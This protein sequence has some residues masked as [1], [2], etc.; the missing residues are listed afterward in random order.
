MNKKYFV[1]KIVFCIFLFGIN[2]SSIPVIAQE[3]LTGHWIAR[4]VFDRNRGGNSFSTATMVLVNK[5]GKKN[6]RVFKNLRIREQGFE[7]QLIRFTSP[8]DIDGT[9]FLTIEKTGY[10]T[11]QFLYLPALR[12]TRRIVSSQKSQQFVN[13][14]FTYEDMERHPVENY[15][16]DLKGEK[17][18]ENID[19]YLLETR[20]QKT[21][22][23]QYSLMKSVI[24]KASFVP[25]FAEYFD[26]KGKHIKTYKV[27]KLELKQNIWTESIVMME[28]ILKKHKTFIKLQDIEYNTNITSD[29]F[30]K[31]ALENY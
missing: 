14:D 31:V 7:K 30:S 11:D 24:S 5:N 16:Y 27:L 29:Q 19:C 18:V 25:I 4:Q 9:G 1:F 20:P 13:S 12:R 21:I 26:Q 22:S 23:S 8:A 3:K 10:E 15:I 6:T 17:I 2:K 28:D